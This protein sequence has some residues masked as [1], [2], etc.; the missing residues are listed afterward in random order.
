MTKSKSVRLW[1]GIGAVGYMVCF[2]IG[3]LCFLSM[4]GEISGEAG[5]V[6]LRGCVLLTLGV[7]TGFVILVFCFNRAVRVRYSDMDL[8]NQLNRSLMEANGNL[9]FEYS[10][11]DRTLR[12]LG[13]ANHTFNAA[14][15]NLGLESLVHLEDFPV[16]NQQIEDVK[17][18]KV[19]ASEV[20]LKDA[21]GNYR[22]CSCR[23]TPVKSVTGRLTWVLGIVEDVDAGHRR[24]TELEVQRELLSGV[25]EHLA[26]SYY[27]IAM[28]DL[29]T[30]KCF[31]MKG[32]P[33]D[34]RSGER[35]SCPG[36][37]PADYGIWQEEAELIRPDYREAFL[38]IFRIDNL[39][40]QVAEGQTMQSL[41]YLRREKPEEPYRRARAEYISY[42]NGEAQNQVIIFI[43]DLRANER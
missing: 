17:R 7:S 16:I 43:K 22:F 10:L 2:A 8:E 18:G 30:E 12:W 25:V 32:C 28:L 27:K 37:G 3:M 34:W 24:E 1:V 39:R 38:E 21:E 35:L 41:V 4:R 33:W 5:A 9:V 29:N 15:R 19:Y 23:M 13:D 14:E 20:R 26:R 42:R 31:F 40:K 36:S 6:A 11:S